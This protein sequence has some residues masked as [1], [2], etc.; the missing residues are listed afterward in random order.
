[1]IRKNAAS[2]LLRC[3]EMASGCLLTVT[4]GPLAYVLGFRT[5]VFLA[6]AECG[7]RMVRGKR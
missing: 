7:W 4:A 1:M 2:G 3:L 5:D 6:V